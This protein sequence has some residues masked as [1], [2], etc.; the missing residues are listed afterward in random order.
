MNKYTKQAKQFL[1]YLCTLRTKILSANVSIWTMEQNYLNYSFTGNV[2]G[3]VAGQPTYK[4]GTFF[5]KS[6]TLTETIF[7]N[8]QSNGASTFCYYK[9]GNFCLRVY[10]KA[11]FDWKILKIGS[12]S[13]RDLIKKFPILQ[14]GWLAPALH[15]HMPVIWVV[16][17]CSIKERLQNDFRQ[18]VYIL[19]V[20]WIQNTK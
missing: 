16:L 3:E 13:F 5:I 14:V 2:G 15:T 9:S 19:T 11:P 1:I 10:Q 4:M 6:L 12:I 7:K 18:A 17:I 20:K 8:F